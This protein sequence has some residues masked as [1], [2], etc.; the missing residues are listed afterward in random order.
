MEPRLCA[1]LPSV[2]PSHVARAALALATMRRKLG[3]GTMHELLVAARAS[4]RLLSDR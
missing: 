2:A 4:M 3:P 1:L